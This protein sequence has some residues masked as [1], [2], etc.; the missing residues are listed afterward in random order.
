MLSKYNH[1]CTTIA[2]MVATLNQRTDIL[3]HDHSSS[4]IKPAKNKAICNMVLTPIKMPPISTITLAMN[5]ITIS[6][7]TIE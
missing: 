1:T 4:T 6:V 3:P 5:A 2:T 7:A